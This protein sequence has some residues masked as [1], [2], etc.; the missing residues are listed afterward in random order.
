MIRETLDYVT[1]SGVKIYRKAVELSICSALD[2]I[3]TRLDTQ[4]GGLLKSSYEYPSRYKRWAV[5]FVNPPLEIVTLN[6]SFTISAL[7]ERG[8]YLLPFIDTNICHQVKLQ[9]II[10][11]EDQISGVIQ[12]STD[13][14]REEERS[15]QPSVFDVIR[16]LLD[17]FFSHDDEYLGLYGTFGYDLIFQFEPVDPIQERPFDQRDLVLYLPDEI[18]IVDY[19]LQKAFNV[20]YEF[21]SGH[22]T[23]HGLPRTGEV[24]DPLGSRSTPINSCDHMP[25]TYADLV[26]HTSEYFRKGN[27]FEVVPSQSFFQKYLG[28]PVFLFETLQKINPSPYGFIFNLGG[29]YLVGA[30]PE[31]FVRVE[32]RRVETC[33]ISG[34]I[35]RGNNAIED[36]H[37]VRLLLNSYKDECELTMCTDVD[38]SDKSRVC[39]PGSVQVIGRRQVEFYSHVIHTVDHVEGTLNSDLDSIDAFLTHI[40]AVTVTGA[41]KKAAVQFIENHERSS[42][43][44][45]GGAVG[46]FKFNGDLNTGLVIRTV[47]LKDSIAEIRVGATLLFDSVPEDEEKETNVKA[48]AMVQAIETA[49]NVAVSGN[50]LFTSSAKVC[51]TKRVLLVDHED[52][53]VHVLANYIRQTG[54]E[55]T[56]LR[57]GFSEIAFEGESPDLVVLSPGPGTPSD[58]HLHETILKCLKE[59]IPLFGVCLGLQGIVETFGGK[60]G[61]LNSPMHGKTSTISV[62]DS[63]S[64]LFRDVPNTFEAGRYHSLYALQNHIPPSLKITAMSED[65]IVMA[66]EHISLPITAVQFHPESIMTLKNGIGLKIIENV[67]RAYIKPRVYELSST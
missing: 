39:E 7:N 35:H 36:A 47:R 67:I 27:L 44:W 24:Y 53:F 63:D 65:N 38:R 56:T 48:A 32:G 21:E 12:K 55:V 16:S 66:V 14:F 42:R 1:K 4:K 9:T 52:S 58:F 40:W 50:L 37:Q 64:R 19:H 6:D 10:R 51:S 61:I 45:Y 46:V 43:R 34:T 23:T 18:V 57:H 30:S 60:L 28:S 15:R 3:T 20:L 31:M 59:K 41:P 5:G 13:S 29:E 54:A 2:S 33:P 17:C 8:K 11:C 49:S 25:G 26:R 22:G 62:T